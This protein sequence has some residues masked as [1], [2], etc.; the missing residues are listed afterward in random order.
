MSELA[1]T[2][3][4]DAAAAGLPNEPEAE[5]EAVDLYAHLRRNESARGDLYAVD[6]KPDEESEDG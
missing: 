5:P 2:Y 1:T 3:A 6:E 4:D